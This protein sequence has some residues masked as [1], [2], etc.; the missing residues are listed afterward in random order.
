MKNIELVSI[1]V[2]MFN[3]Q[4]YIKECI[5]SIINQAYKDI[6]V[7]MVD[8]G[9]TDNSLKICKELKKKTIEFI[10]LN[11]IIQE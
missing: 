10:L 8:D 11:K 2:P 5:E 7:I 3:A 1:V 9:S 4:K 6:Q